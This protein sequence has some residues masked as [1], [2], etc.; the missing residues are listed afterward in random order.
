MDPDWTKR[1]SCFFAPILALDNHMRSE[2]GESPIEIDETVVV[3]VTRDGEDSRHYFI[4]TQERLEA[5]KR[6]NVIIVPDD[7]V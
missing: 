7:D 2:C 4:A 3:T 6:V 1:E 5:A